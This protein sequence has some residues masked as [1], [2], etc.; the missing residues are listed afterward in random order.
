MRGGG[1]KYRVNLMFGS[2]TF[3]TIPR[4]QCSRLRREEVGA[5]SGRAGWEEE[6]EPEREEGSGRR[7]KEGGAQRVPG[8]RRIAADERAGGSQHPPNATPKLPHS[9]LARPRGG[10]A[11][12]D[13]HVPVPLL[14]HAVDAL[15][16]L[17]PHLPGQRQVDRAGGRRQGQPG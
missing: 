12:H 11:L 15:E 17:A 13:A 1:G 5:G 7:K 16:V 14:A 9:S 2:L 4:M 10:L 6:E 3:R 8:D